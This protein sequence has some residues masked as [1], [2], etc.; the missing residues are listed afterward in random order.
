MKRILVLNGPNLD[1]LG[2]REPGVYGS[3]T[4]A[5]LER[6]VTEHGERRGAA[7]ACFQSNSEGELV[8]A[9]H[10]ARG[11]Y[12]G[13]VYNPGAHTHYS[14]ALRDAVGGI[15]VPCAE[16]HISDVDA[17][18][19]FRRVSVIA[20]ACVAQVK[21]RGFQGYCD[22]LDLLL[23]GVSERLGEGYEQRYPA[24]QVIVGGRGL[25]QEDEEGEAVPLTL[26]AGTAQT[27]AADHPQAPIGNPAGLP[28][29][30]PAQ[31]D[32]GPRLDRL[33]AACADDGIDA[34]LV[35]D[36]SNIAWLTAFD[37]VFDD[38]S[39]HAL[40]VTPSAAVLHTDSRYVDSARAAASDGPI[41]VDDARKTHAKFVA[42]A[43]EGPSNA[44]RSSGADAA[45]EGVRGGIPES[46]L[47]STPANPTQP[48]VL[49][50]ED[51]LSLGEFRALEATL[52]EAPGSA[53]ILRETSR[54]VLGLRAVKEPTEVVRLR[55]AQA[56]TDAAFAHIVAFMRP[57]MTEREV[58]IELEDFMRRHGAEGLAFS[59]I[60][61]A[62]P[63]GASPHAVPGAT[64]LE[65][66]QCVVLD[67]GA[68]AYGYCSDM[69]RTVFLGEP[70]E[71][72]RTAYEAIRQ[73]NEQVEAALRP[74]VTG[75]D[76]HELAERV[77]ADHGFA[78]KMGHSLG[79]GVG[80]DIHEEPNLSPR[81]P[82]PLVPGNVVTVEPGV[83]LSGEFGMRLEDF[84]VITR[85]GFAV[86]TQSTHDMVII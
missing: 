17:R 28:L 48:A 51:S 16:V 21:G 43:L 37:G 26:P 60:V 62:G 18:E 46:T 14:Y 79:H 9:V 44:E 64:L 50:I 5:D 85:D 84:G 11:A 6:L 38:E 49:G 40:L 55:A 41:A 67:F 33:R 8:E 72:L 45:P 59:S 20:P 77:L 68:R 76:M 31:G 54:F 22:A 53:P 81:N 32:A 25:L 63:N 13:I 1:M 24:G 39:A 23:E 2:V 3:E 69:T 61:A 29:Q 7:V 15:D 86:F 65:A 75:K 27:G 42:D 10:A 58:Q 74:G 80:I 36:T 66:G 73:A 4:L 57:G 56:V 52:A 47:G 71:R 70:D 35:R 78:G 30:P 19:P 12:D 82:H 34:F 83:Y